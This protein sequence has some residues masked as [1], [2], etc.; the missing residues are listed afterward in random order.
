MVEE[1][2]VTCEWSEDE[3]RNF[4]P[5]GDKEHDDVAANVASEGGAEF[6]YREDAPVASLI[7]H[8][9]RPTRESI[10]TDGFV[11][12]LLTFRM[13]HKDYATVSYD[14]SAVMCTLSMPDD[15]CVSI[16][17]RGRYEVSM[18]GE[19]N[20]KVIKGAHVGNACSITSM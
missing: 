11:S 12:I 15:L 18:G 17:G 20:L 5:A 3:I 16:S 10:V 2:L 7:D 1:Q 4:G 14:Q 19:V 8:R 9:G 13:E 6:P